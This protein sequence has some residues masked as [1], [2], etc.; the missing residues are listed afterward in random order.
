CWRLMT[1]T[2]SYSSN[3]LACMIRRSAI[4]RISSMLGTGVFSFFF[5]VPP[6]D[7]LIS[8]AP[9]YSLCSV[10]SLDAYCSLDEGCFTR[11]TDQMGYFRHF[12]KIHQ[13]AIDTFRSTIFALYLSRHEP[14]LPTRYNQGLAG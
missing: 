10:L 4:R 11:I 6:P 2:I 5:P 3:T 7:L 13:E 14:T 12:K 1:D 8:P 9:L